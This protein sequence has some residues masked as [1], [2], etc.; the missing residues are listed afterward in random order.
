MCGGPSTVP[1]PPLPAPAR[2]A[3][4]PRCSRGHACAPSAFAQGDYARGWLCNACMRNQR[5]E[6]WFCA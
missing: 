1:F 3:A 5:G 6:R 2:G 4:A